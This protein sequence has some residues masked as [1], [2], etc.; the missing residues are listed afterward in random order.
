[1]AVTRPLPFQCFAQLLV[2]GEGLTATDADKDKDD[3]SALGQADN[4]VDIQREYV[5]IGVRGGRAQL[6]REALNEFVDF[7]I[8]RHV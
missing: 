4:V 3:G 8:W 1:M 6:L 7:G 2:T 5:G